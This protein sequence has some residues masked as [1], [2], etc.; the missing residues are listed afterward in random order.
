MPRIAWLFIINT[1]ITF[2]VM[3]VLGLRF[4]ISDSY[5]LGV[6]KR[7]SGDVQKHSLV[8]SCLPKEVANVMIDRGY[9]PAVGNC[10]GYPPVI[11]KIYA[12]AGDIVHVSDAV[13]I[14]GEL[15]ANTRLMSVDSN[16]RTLTPAP[17]TL[18][19]A[20]HVWLM[21]DNSPHSYDARYFGQTP[22]SLIR[23]KLRPLWTVE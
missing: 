22:D 7:V 10:G 13:V 1:A 8:E 18:L 3:A 20:N 11:K 19:A 12:T 23:S 4:N 6:Y 2:S 21:S 15:I 14:N 17:N 9:I 5:P 16:S